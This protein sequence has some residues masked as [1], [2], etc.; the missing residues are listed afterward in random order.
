MSF[1]IGFGSSWSQEL[2]AKRPSFV[3][4][5]TYTRPA[6]ASSMAA[7]VPI[8]AEY[9]Q[10]REPSASERLRTFAPQA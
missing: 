8:G 3:G 10:C 1:V 7:R 4:A 9:V 2:F 6:S 5:L